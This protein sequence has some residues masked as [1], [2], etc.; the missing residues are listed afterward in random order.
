MALI[1]CPECNKEVSDKAEACIHCGYPL[2]NWKKV[3]VNDNFFQISNLKL[4]Q[5]FTLGNCW[6]VMGDSECLDIHEGE[7][8][9]FLDIDEEVLASLKIDSIVIQDK[10]VTLRFKDIN[11]EYL[12]IARYVIKSEHKINRSILAADTIKDNNQVKCPK[13]GSTQIQAV[14]R[15]WSLMAGI[16]TNQVDRVCLN[17][18]HKF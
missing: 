9:D 16:L 5:Y 6:V 7:F 15:K 13:C 10:T 11:L 3:N 18:K 12:E 2:S 17:C 1:N 14:S 4:N 8:V